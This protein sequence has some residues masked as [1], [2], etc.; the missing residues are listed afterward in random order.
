MRS[1]QKRLKRL[2]ELHHFDPSGCA[3]HS[4]QWLEYWDRQVYN[5]M[6]DQEHVP[7]TVEAVRAIMRYSDD[8]ASLVGSIAQTPGGA[9]AASPAGN[10]PR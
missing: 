10:P 4:P 1:L 6:T 5:H 2:E 3:P 7:L 8:P 9:N